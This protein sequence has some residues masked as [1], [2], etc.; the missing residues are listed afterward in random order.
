MKAPN[1]GTNEMAAAH[2]RALKKVAG[3]DGGGKKRKRRSVFASITDFVN[4]IEVK[5]CPGFPQSNCAVPRTKREKY[6]LLQK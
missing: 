2:R 1:H 5:G 4:G 6:T 3:K